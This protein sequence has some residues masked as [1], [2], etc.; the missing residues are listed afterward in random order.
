MIE[1]SADDAE[2]VAR[3]VARTWPELAWRRVETP[4][5]LDDAFRE[6]WDAVVADYT[7]PRLDAL[8]ALR[9][10][11]AGAHDYVMKGNLRRRAS[12]SSRSRAGTRRRRLPFIT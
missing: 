10:V 1:D 8:E 3:E 12:A 6:E 4:E 2:L 5:Q 7:L 9:N 11:R